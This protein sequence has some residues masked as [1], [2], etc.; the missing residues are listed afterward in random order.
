MNYIILFPLSHTIRS[1]SLS[2]SPSLSHTYAL[3]LFLYPS[4]THTYAL[5]LSPS[6][7]H[8]YALSLSPSPSLSHTYVLSLFLFLPLSHTHTLYLSLPLPLSTSANKFSYDQDIFLELLISPVV[9]CIDILL[10]ILS[11]QEV[12]TPFI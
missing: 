7:T 3:S 6:L 2:L 4:L 1:I 5:S 8:T 11:V 10:D 12:V 9:C